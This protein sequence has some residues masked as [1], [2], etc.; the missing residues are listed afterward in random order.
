MLVKTTSL[1]NVS[2]FMPVF[3]NRHHLEVLK[4][5]TCLFGKLN[6]TEAGRLY[7]LSEILKFSS[8]LLPITVGQCCD[9][10]IDTVM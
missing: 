3:S 1:N 7:F 5:G 2:S 8:T 9:Q 6:G 10:L 4:Q